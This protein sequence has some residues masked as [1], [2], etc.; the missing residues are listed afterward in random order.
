MTNKK[1]LV[2][3]IGRTGRSC[4]DFFKRHKI[5]FKAFDTRKSESINISD[6]EKHNPYLFRFEDFEEEILSQML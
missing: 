1:K 2:I 5:S 4:I 6:D 3:G